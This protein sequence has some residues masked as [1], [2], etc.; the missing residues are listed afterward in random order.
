MSL[1]DPKKNERHTSEIAAQLG[2]T[3]RTVRNWCRSGRLQA[4]RTPGGHWRITNRFAAVPREDRPDENARRPERPPVTAAPT[5]TVP[6][7][8]HQADADDLAA[9]IRS[10]GLDP[11]QVIDVIR[12]LAADLIPLAA[13]PDLAD[14]VNRAALAHDAESAARLAYEKEIRRRQR[15]IAELE[16]QLA[17]LGGDSGLIHYDDEH[18][19]GY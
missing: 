4:I 3:A 8:A 15:Q 2:V 17:L 19:P 9:A 11:A 14:R 16:R 7:Q 6:D 1:F 18:T 10:L 12:D 5:T 13:L